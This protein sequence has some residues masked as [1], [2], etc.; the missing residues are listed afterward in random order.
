MMPK[1][2][3]LKIHGF[4]ILNFAINSVK[5]DRLI[6]DSITLSGNCLKIKNTIYQLEDYKN[7]YVIGAGKASAYMASAVE[8]LLG[9]WITDG[10]VVAK[11]DHK[12]VCKK[13]K[14]LEAGHPN[15][16]KKSLAAADEILKLLSKT[17]KDDLVIFLLSGGGSSVLEKLP[18]EI[19]LEDF[20][21][22]NNTL[23]N[24]GADITEI[25]RVRKKISL[26][27]GGKLAKYIYP[28]ECITLIISDV[29]G[30]DIG[31]I[32][33]GPTYPDETK[34][35]DLFEI[36]DKYKIMNDV[37]VSILKYL[38]SQNRS[39]DDADIGDK[40][41]FEKI[42]HFIIGSNKIA[43]LSALN[44]ASEFGYDSKIIS[45]RIE[46]EAKTIGREIS[47]IIKS[48]FETASERKNPV[49]ILFGG[50]TIV[51]VIGSGKGGRNQELV[52]SALL[53]LGEVTANFLLISCG[54]DGTDGPT[55]A[56]GAYIDNS[57][58]TKIEELN[59]LPSVYLNNNDS[60]N[61]FSKIGQLIK[62]GPTG[63]NVM[64]IIIILVE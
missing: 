37:P 1:M 4:E 50:E 30:D 35:G 27:K 11:Y 16:D 52:L 21:K 3:N 17:G 53:E 42:K 57:T 58:W 39:P 25:N 38:D 56:A 10:I 32:A 44:L 24:C 47:N 33:S 5:P 26:I 55:D 8:N 2:S 60:Y 20:I 12:T 61:F 36:F 14:I 64:D 62:T 7:I 63:T 15:L 31:F 48:A 9:S 28:S 59:L 45:D 49:C 22:L 41:Y 29:I 54:T 13:I 43:L 34:I 40:K 46:G 18:P 51:N 23:I 19:P 6:K